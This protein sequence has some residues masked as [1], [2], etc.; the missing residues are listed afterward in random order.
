MATIAVFDS[1]KAP[2][3]QCK[4]LLPWLKDLYIPKSFDQWAIGTS[5]KGHKQLPFS[6]QHVC[7]EY[8]TNLQG[9][10]KSNGRM[11]SLFS[12]GL[13]IAWNCSNHLYDFGFAEKCILPWKCFPMMV[14]KWW[15]ITCPVAV[16]WNGSLPCV[17]VLIR[18]NRKP[19]F[20]ASSAH[21]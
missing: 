14:R 5:A 11:Q 2:K 6:T 1:T 13:S 4:C 20:T 18:G 12:S 10:H 16:L 19:F 9:K 15:R 7:Q 8:E 17:P 21:Q 3:E